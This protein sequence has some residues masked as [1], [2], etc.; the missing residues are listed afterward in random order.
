MYPS[1]H[2]LAA[3]NMPEMHGPTSKASGEQTRK[4][5]KILT[6]ALHRAEEGAFSGAFSANEVFVVNLEGTEF[7]EQMGEGQ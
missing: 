2:F 6:K 1:N 7:S 4:G 5:I 3:G